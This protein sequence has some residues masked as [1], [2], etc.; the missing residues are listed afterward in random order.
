[1]KFLSLLEH[2]LNEGPH[3]AREW[4]FGSIISGGIKAK[5]GSFQKIEDDAI[6]LS[7]EGF[8]DSIQS[9]SIT[10]IEPLALLCSGCNSSGKGW[11]RVQY[12]GKAW[13]LGN[14]PGKTHGPQMHNSPFCGV[15]GRN[16]K[17][18]YW[19]WLV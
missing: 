7:N 12:G 1:M 6:L 18:S 3:E 8:P 16:V 15:E 13:K 10:P 11:R 19:S 2:E 4:E 14:R 17:T 5:L 9:Q